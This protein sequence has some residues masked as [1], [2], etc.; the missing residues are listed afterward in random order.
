[1]PGLTEIRRVLS[2]LKQMGDNACRK[3]AHWRRPPCDFRQWHAPTRF[4]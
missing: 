4:S 1:M 3:R 2:E